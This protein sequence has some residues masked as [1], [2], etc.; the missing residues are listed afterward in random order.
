MDRGGRG[1]VLIRLVQNGLCV[2]DDAIKL[3]DILQAHAETTVPGEPD[4]FLA[5]WR[6]ATGVT[7]EARKVLA[8]RDVRR[9]DI[10]IVAFGASFGFRVVANLI[11]SAIGLLSSTKVVASFKSTEPEARAWLVEK[12]AAYFARKGEGAA[13][14]D[15]ER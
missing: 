12:K 1:R 5:D 10:F 9:D 6:E 11:F 14:S 2:E 13:P 3:T 15:G 7:N 4:F 8:T